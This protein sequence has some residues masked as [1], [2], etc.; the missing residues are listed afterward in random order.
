MAT[1]TLNAA[2]DP[3]VVNGSTD[4]VPGA[5]THT[6]RDLTLHVSGVL[7]AEKSGSRM[8]TDTAIVDYTTDG[9]GSWVLIDNLRG[10]EGG[11]T[12]N[13]NYGPFSVSVSTALANIKVRLR[14]FPQVPGPTLQVDTIKLA[15]SDAGVAPSSPRTHCDMFGF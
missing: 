3:I 6:S 4:F 2:S 14:T 8:Y 12:F 9:G 13:D 11:F 10:E 5:L 1:E 15:C 7:N